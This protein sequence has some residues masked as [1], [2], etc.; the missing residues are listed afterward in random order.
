MDSATNHY[1]N[2]NKDVDGNYAKAKLGS[3]SSVAN[4]QSSDSS[5]KSRFF[6]GPPSSSNADPRNQGGVDASPIGSA[7]VQQPSQPPR[8]N[9][10]AHNTTAASN[11]PNTRESEEEYYLSLPLDPSDAK[12]I[13]YHAK[14]VYL[15]LDYVNA[16]RILDVLAH[17]LTI[18]DEMLRAKVFG[19][20]ICFYR[21]RSFPEAMV[22]FDELETLAL[23][24]HSAGDVSLSC[25]Y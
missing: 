11:T 1:K 22:R 20:G 2:A 16:R 18:D 15:I 8:A 19:Y 5:G 7:V 12:S 23:E 14:A 9:P 10:H 13:L 25:I 21:Q 6:V 17:H 3:R 4:H 24:H